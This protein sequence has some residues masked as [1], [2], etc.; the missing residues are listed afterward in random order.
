MLGPSHAANRGKC[1]VAISLRY[2]FSIADSAVFI[3]PYIC[4]KQCSALVP[5]C[6]AMF[7]IFHGSASVQPTIVTRRI[8]P[9]RASYARQFTVEYHKPVICAMHMYKPDRGSQHVNAVFVV[10]EKISLERRRLCVSSLEQFPNT[11]VRIQSMRYRS[12]IEQ[13]LY[14]ISTSKIFDQLD[15]LTKYWY[16]IFFLLRKLLRTECLH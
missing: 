11:S 12:S 9:S 13:L 14:E 2:K 10:A 4:T 3:P 1:R 6:F 15:F 5:D 7:E 16:V 8:R